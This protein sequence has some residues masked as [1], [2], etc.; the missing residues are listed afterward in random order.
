MREFIE[1]LISVINESGKFGGAYLFN[2]QPENARNRKDM[3]RKRRVVYLEPE[4][5]EQLGRSLGINKYDVTI[6]IYI[7][8][9]NKKHS[10]LEDLSLLDELNDVMQNANGFVNNKYTFS[11]LVR[12]TFE[13][14]SDHDNVS[15][16]FNEYKTTLTDYSGYRYRNLTEGTFTAI[17]VS[18][19]TI[20]D[21]L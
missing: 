14:D 17:D 15:Q 9:D 18:N 19:I 11:S 8:N 7:A 12:E 21:T 3:G 2:E 5:N 20:T 1:Y 6:R 4:I 10:K 13:F 16:P